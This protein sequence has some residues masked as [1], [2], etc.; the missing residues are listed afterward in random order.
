MVLARCRILDAKIDVNRSYVFDVKRSVVLSPQAI[1]LQA[2]AER[3][4]LEEIKAKAVQA[5][6]LQ[7]K[8]HWLW[9]AG[10]LLRHNHLSLTTVTTP[11]C[12]R[13][14]V[15][16]DGTQSQVLAAWQPEMNQFIEADGYTHET[17]QEY[18]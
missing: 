16:R 17:Y 9:D 12:Q 6:L 1:H 3:K 18:W 5:G 11:V 14:D 8:A 15:W 13:H 10:S 2:A 4:A 7:Q